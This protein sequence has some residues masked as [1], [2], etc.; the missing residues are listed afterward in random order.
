MRDRLGG[1][2]R[3]APV[4]AILLGAPLLGVGAFA[5]FAAN[6]QPAGDMPGQ[7]PAVERGRAIF[8]ATCAA[9]HGTDL[10]GGRGPSLFNADRLAT[11]GAAGLRDKIEKGGAGTEMPAF[12]DLYSA[13]DID[14]MIAYLTARAEQLR[15]RATARGDLFAPPPPPNPDGQRIHTKTQDIQL[16]VVEKG[17]E[18]PYGMDLLADGR[19][20]VSERT[21][22]G[23]LRIVD[24]AGK[25]P[26]VRVTGLPKI[27]QGQDAGLLDVAVGP[28]HATD[29]WIYIAYSDD[30]P[31]LPEPPPPAPG[32]P[33]FQ[34][35]RK[36]SMT[37]I[38]RG[39]IDANNRWAEHQEIFRA[40][41]SFYT[42]SGSHY[43]ARI[44]F[45]TQGHLFFSVGERGDMRN[46]QNLMT[47]LGKIHRVNLDGSIPADNPFVGRKDALPSIWSYGHRNPEGLAWG[48]GTGLLWE[49]E[50]GPVGGDEVNVIVKGGNYGW[51]VVSKGMQPGI[52]DVSAPGMIDPVAWYF[53]TLA[54][55]G[56]GF[57]EG[58]RYKGWKGSLFVTGLNGQ[59]LRRLT[60]KG[61]Q[62]VDQE[63]VFAS[64]G[65]VRDVLTGPDGLLYILMTN[66]TG[67]G[68]GI[69]LTN[70]VVGALVRVRPISWQQVEFRYPGS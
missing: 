9:C 23:Y 34:V 1:P 24:L 32:A 37:V 17:L 35:K 41:W 7:T 8:A 10:S 54:P 27:H 69:D 40:P 25:T 2:G 55:S 67:Q 51:G 48:P 62:V 68:T 52:K 12:K 50:H 53:P 66:P 20:I 44:L 19:V 4:L 6:A 13:A 70:P 36:P 56:I 39:K 26:S 45:D 42:P 61:D 5:S 46:A 60:V 30:D 31:A 11:L 28:N 16:E 21:G 22:D 49:S 47:P 63:V 65:R 33:G 14:G 38:A 64:L 43:G 58:D 29:G 3:A 15:P 59:Q 18:T 57:Y